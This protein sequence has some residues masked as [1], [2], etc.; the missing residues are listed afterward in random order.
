[1]Y[2]AM[3]DGLPCCAYDMT[4]VTDQEAGGGGEGGRRL[5]SS[6]TLTTPLVGF[7]TLSVGLVALFFSP[8]GI[9]SINVKTVMSIAAKNIFSCM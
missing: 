9:L 1:M 3:T 6:F 5:H 2:C 7:G 4:R 8:H